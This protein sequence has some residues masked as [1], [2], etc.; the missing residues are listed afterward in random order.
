MTHAFYYEDKLVGIITNPRNYPGGIDEFLGMLSPD[1]G[2]ARAVKIIM[3]KESFK[4]IPKKLKSL[5]QECYEEDAKWQT[6]LAQNPA[7][8]SHFVGKLP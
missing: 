4:G 2:L 8:A 7:P 5:C 3:P 6:L 1:E